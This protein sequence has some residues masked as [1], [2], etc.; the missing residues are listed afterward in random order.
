VGLFLHRRWGTALGI[1]AVMIGLSRV[2]VG[3]HYPGDILAAAVI[4]ALAG[5]EVKVYS[6]WTAS[7]ATSVALRSVPVRRDTSS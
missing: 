1:V 4:A 2:W 7:P 3:V 6:L 5:V